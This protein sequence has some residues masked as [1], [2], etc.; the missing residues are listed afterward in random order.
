MAHD[1]FHNIIHDIA[2]LNSL[3]V[4]LV[5]VH[6]AR[7]QINTELHQAKVSTPF[8]N[9]TR[10]T[11]DRALPYVINAVGSLRIQIEALLSM[12]LSNSPM[13]G[14]RIRV[15]SGNFVTAKP[16][17]VR[18][19]VDF[20]HSGEVRR[21]DRKAINELLDK[22]DIAL[23]SN[24][25]YS[26]TGEVFNLTME[27]VATQTAIAL[28]A[29]KLICFSSQEG[30]KDGAGELIRELTPTQGQVVIEEHPENDKDTLRSLEAASK[31]CDQVVNRAHLI[32]YVDDGALIK[33]LFTVDGSGTLVSREAYEKIRRANIEDIGGILDLLTPLEE[34]GALVKRSRELLEAEIEQFTIIERDNMIIGCAALYPFDNPEKTGEL[35]CL[36]I[37]PDFRDG[38]RGRLLLNHIEKQASR[39]GLSRLFVLTTQTEHWF[40]ENGFVKSSVDELPDTRKSLYNFQRNS[41]VFKKPIIR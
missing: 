39:L 33:E 9:N 30:V 24:L 27:D 4:R 18:K 40:L 2:L 34:Q 20:Q 5:L 41:K 35:A 32:S 3:G 25:G 13:H 26:P 17:G 31:V 7:K 10:I 6:G 37:H 8:E 28:E 38:K 15:C 29:D 16:I 21:I 23:L 12:G 1:N 11:H 36:A 19:G 14:A 22:G